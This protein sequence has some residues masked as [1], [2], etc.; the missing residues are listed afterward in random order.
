MARWFSRLRLMT[1]EKTDERV[2]L[3]NEILNAIRV[4]KMYAWEKPFAKMVDDARE[5]ATFSSK[6]FYGMLKMDAR[7]QIHHG[8]QKCDRPHYIKKL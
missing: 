5:S 1:A 8:Q 2:G 4:I 3:M 6:I 7:H